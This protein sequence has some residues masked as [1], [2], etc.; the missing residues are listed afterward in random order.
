MPDQSSDGRA[1]RSIPE[2][3][4]PRSGPGPRPH[5]GHHH[6]PRVDPGG[7]PA[8]GRFRGR[9]AAAF[10]LTAALFVAE[11]IVGL[12]AASL[13]VVA[14][15][16]HLAADVVTLG[17]A[18]LATHIATRPDATGRRTYGRYR[19]EVFATGLAVLLMVGVGVFVVVEAIGRIGGGAEVSSGPMA[20]IGVAGLVVNVL[21]L[22]LLRA[23]SGESLTVRGA[24]LE[25]L[26]DAAGSVGIVLAAVLIA[27]TGS[28]VWDVVVA[29]AIG[30][31]VV[32]RAAGLGR[33]VLRV[34]GQQVPDGIDPAAVA[35]D[36]SGVPGVSDVH[37]LHLWEL[38]SGMT[39]AT[40]HLVSA[41]GADQHGVLDG[42]RDVLAARYRIEHA[43]LQVEP[44]DHTSCHHIDW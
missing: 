35:A 41:D 22:M 10:L 38:T 23:G 9:L 8:S 32:V 40:A 16:G 2:G 29:V 28:P 27:T 42:A 13:A 25:V 24:Y 30:V 18:L 33:S 6:G 4:G 15:A 7:V 39:V 19:A 1:D 14:D 34:L 17:A 26:G 37:D 5:A 36:L 20:V 21:C 3:A 44:A 31:F 11:L 12:L 43:T